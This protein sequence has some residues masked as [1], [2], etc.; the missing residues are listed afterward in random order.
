MPPSTILVAFD[1]SPQAEM[2]CKFAIR[3]IAQDSDHL[4]IAVTY[5]EDSLKDASRHR[6]RAFAEQ[7]QMEVAK[8]KRVHVDFVVEKAG[9]SDTGATLLRMSK[10]FV[11]DLVVCG[12]TGKNKFSTVLGSTSQYLLQHADR[13]VVIYREPVETKP[14]MAT[15][16]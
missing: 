12:S 6:A 14:A 5:P 7:L 16:K 15:W 4:I 10:T 1:F 8:T 9:V 2:A 3:T 11:A 13:P